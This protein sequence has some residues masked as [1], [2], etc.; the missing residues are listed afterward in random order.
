MMLVAAI[1][2]PCCF[3]ASRPPARGAVAILV[4]VQCFAVG[5]VYDHGPIPCARRR[6][7]RSGGGGGD[8]SHGAASERAP[9]GG[10][11]LAFAF[12]ALLSLGY[13]VPRPH[14]RH[15]LVGPLWTGSVVFSAI[16]GWLVSYVVCRRGGRSGSADVARRRW[17]LL[18]C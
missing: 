15:R 16:I 6:Y 12:P 3:P 1:N 2:S 18:P 13:F 5:F 8:P 4:G 9:A 14:G 11:R 10:V 17:T 7:D